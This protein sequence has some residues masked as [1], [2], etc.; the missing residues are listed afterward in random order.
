ME[1]NEK[2]NANQGQSNGAHCEHE[3]MPRSNSIQAFKNVWRRVI[4]KRLGCYEIYVGN[5]NYLV[6]TGI[7]ERSDSFLIG[8]IPV[9]V[10]LL[11]DFCNQTKQGKIENETY[12]EARNLI[13]RWRDQQ[14]FA[15]KTGL[16]K[17]TVKGAAVDRIDLQQ[18][19]SSECELGKTGGGSYHEDWCFPEQ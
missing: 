9:M 10:K 4:N 16:K 18:L 13:N 17:P 1:D 19:Y 6:A 12:E 3:R 7:G 5:S 14:T 8:A 11:Q 15:V 2:D